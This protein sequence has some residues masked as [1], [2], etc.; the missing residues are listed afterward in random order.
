M[1]NFRPFIR[2]G[3]FLLV[4][5]DNLIDFE[6]DSL[7]QYHIEKAGIATLGLY[8]RDEVRLSGVVD[9]GEDGRVTKFIE[10]PEFGKERSH[11]V[12]TGVYVLDP[13][14]LGYIPTHGFSDFA[15]DIFPALIEQEEKVYGLLVKGRV[16]PVDTPELVKIAKGE[17]ER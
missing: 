11:L 14:I 9:L 3:P 6:I 4:Y 16:I 12:N 13:R 8:Y 7:I 1:N 10:K 17:E 5:G 15:K 2:N